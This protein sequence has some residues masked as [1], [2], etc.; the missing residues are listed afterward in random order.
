M[1]FQKNRAGNHDG[2]QKDN[3]MHRG[4]FYIII[5]LILDFTAMLISGQISL[6][7]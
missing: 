3:V 4:E 2:T 1:L 6:S 7:Q 5:I